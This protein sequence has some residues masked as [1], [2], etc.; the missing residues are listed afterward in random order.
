M[1][2]LPPLSRSDYGDILLPGVIFNYCAQHVLKLSLG[3]REHSLR[4]KVS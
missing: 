4:F 2:V 1:C 3:S